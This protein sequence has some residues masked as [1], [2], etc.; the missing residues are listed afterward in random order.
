MLL[1]E[2]AWKRL[3]YGKTN[4]GRGVDSWGGSKGIG[5]EPAPYAAGAA[6]R[7]GEGKGGL[8][9]WESRAAIAP[10]DSDGDG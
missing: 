2:K 10:T 4:R 9:A 6:A 1:S 7:E 3:G 5:A 8:G